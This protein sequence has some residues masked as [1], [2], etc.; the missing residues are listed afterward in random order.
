MKKRPSETQI[1]KQSLSAENDFAEDDALWNL[2]EKGNEPPQ[3]S[4]LFSRNVLRKVRGEEEQRPS[5]WTALSRPKQAFGA[6]MTGAL[7]VTLLLLVLAT[8]PENSPSTGTLSQNPTL[9]DI[10]SE[11]L[12]DSY[13]DEELLLVAAD[14]PALFSDETVI[15]MLF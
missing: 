8:D 3:A 13:L 7:A 14:E 10:D 5:W 6:V 2:L 12:L 4:P 11:D 9:E 1:P 15:T